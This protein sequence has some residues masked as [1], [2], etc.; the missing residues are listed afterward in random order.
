M[1]ITLQPALCCDILQNLNRLEKLKMILLMDTHLISRLEEEFHT[2]GVFLMFHYMRSEKSL[3][4][5][6]FFR[7]NIL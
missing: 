4:S 3:I 5:L 1:R 2:E 7:V 6:K